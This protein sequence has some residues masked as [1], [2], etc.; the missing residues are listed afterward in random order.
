[1]PRACATGKRAAAP[2]AAPP[3]P[4][5]SPPPPLPPAKEQPPPARPHP[6]SS[7][8]AP[9]IAPPREAC[10]HCASTDFAAGPAFQAR[11]FVVCSAC[12]VRRRA[13]PSE[14]E[15]KWRETR[16]SPQPPPTT[17]TTTSPLPSSLHHSPGH[18][19]PRGVPGQ[20]NGLPADASDGG[21]RG[22]L[23]LQRGEC[24]GWRE[25]SIGVGGSGRTPALSAL[26][27][28]HTIFSHK[29]LSF[30]FPPLV[31]TQACQQVI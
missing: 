23:V 5:P 14:V 27:L 17:T 15:R 28:R 11:T 7:T 6:R 13:P 18:G 16:R 4:P 20:G 12:Q 21:V 29:P 31:A 25:E 8:K 30:S 9:L 10:I 1:M 3:P 19:H 2:A 26:S 22:A 24:V